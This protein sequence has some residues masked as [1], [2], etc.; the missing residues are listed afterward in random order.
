[1]NISLHII[2]ESEIGR[3]LT[4][5]KIH[6]RNLIKE[7]AKAAINDAFKRAKMIADQD[8]FL[9]DVQTEE[10]ERLQRVLQIMIPELNDKKTERQKLQ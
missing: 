8:A 1:M 5:A 3:S 4:A 6:D 7:T 10:A 9:G 2:Y